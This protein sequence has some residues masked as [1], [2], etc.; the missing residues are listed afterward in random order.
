VPNWIEFAPP[1]EFQDRDGIVRPIA[2]CSLI[3]RFEFNER[4]EQIQ[5]RLALA[6]AGESWQVLYDRD[7]RLRFYVDRCLQLNGISPEWV[8]LE[9]V[10]AF[11]F[12]RFDEET[13]EYLPGWLVELNSPKQ[14]PHKVA[15]EKPLTLAEILAALSLQTSV[16]D[17]LEVASSI[18]AEMVTAISEERNR[19]MRQAHEGKPPQSSKPTREELMELLNK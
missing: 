8:T 12:H 13:D 16:S 3:G 11:L 15:P 14:A 10:E 1:A 19:M 17:A 4:I 6:E 9:M 7:K 2:T 18:P 5:S